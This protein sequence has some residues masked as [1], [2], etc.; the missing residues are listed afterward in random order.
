[1]GH[2]EVSMALA[3]LRPRESKRHNEAHY[4]EMLMMLCNTEYST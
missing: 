1:M 4:V 3:E 2:F